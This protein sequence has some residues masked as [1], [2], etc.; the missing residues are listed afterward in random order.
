MRI[1][2]YTTIETLGL[3][4]ANSTFRLNRL[5]NMDDI[6][7]GYTPDFGSWAKYIYISSWCKDSTENIPNWYMYTNKMRGVRIEAD[8]DFLQLEEENKTG[9]VLNI[10]NSNFVGFKINY[11]NKKDFLNDVKYRGTYLPEVQS[12]IDGVRGYPNENLYDIGLVKPKAWEFQDETRF[13]IIGISKKYMAKFG[14]FLFQKVQNAI[15]NGSPNDIPY[16]DILFNR[17]NLNNANFILG[18]EATDEDYIKL[19]QIIM[20]Y[21]PG[22]TGYIQKS[23]LM[24]RFKE[25]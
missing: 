4:L 23:K 5:D 6:T 12:G 10:K 14:D 3:I 17:D 7:E 19:Q 8:S 18:P 13:R 16:I 1:F 21:L 20:N 11:E 25:K 24:I 15:I 2:H 22:H 9:K